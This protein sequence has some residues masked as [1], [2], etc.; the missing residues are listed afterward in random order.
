MAQARDSA[1]MS[2]ALGSEALL[3]LLEPG[4]RRT[5][6]TGT[7]AIQLD[8]TREMAAAAAV[9]VGEQARRRGVRETVKRPTRPTSSGCN[10][11]AWCTR[12]PTAA[13]ASSC[14]HGPR[15]RGQRGTDRRVARPGGHLGA[16]PGERARLRPGNL[17][18]RL[19]AYS[20]ERAVPRGPLPGRRPHGPGIPLGLASIRLIR[21][22]R[23]T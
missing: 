19:P 10:W 16:A 22:N 2:G 18:L 5:L 21:V 4:W 15:R 7:P 9:A 14:R 3:D 8:V 23:V 1:G 13:A 6:A 12:V 11:T 17:L 20:R